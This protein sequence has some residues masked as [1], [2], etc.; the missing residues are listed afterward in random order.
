MINRTIA[1]L[2]GKKQYKSEIYIV[3]DNFTATFSSN[4][5]LESL[6]WT[7]H[8]IYEASGFDHLSFDEDILEKASKGI[9]VF[10]KIRE[11]KIFS[12]S[13]SS[14]TLFD[15]TR[16]KNEDILFMNNKMIYIPDKILKILREQ[17]AKL[18][19]LDLLR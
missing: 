13:S 17:D 14:V 9:G 16:P 5:L 11:F 1:K 10:G 15:Y 6:K 18:S 8:G 4:S 7:I 3:K 19:E 2:L 12:V